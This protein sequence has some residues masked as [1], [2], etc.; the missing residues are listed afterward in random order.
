[1]PHT[2]ELQ[3]W[4][5]L[6]N[7]EGEL[8]AE[9]IEHTLD[10]LRVLASK[11]LG[12]FPRVRRWAETDDVLQDSIIRLHRALAEVRPESPRQFYGLAATQI[13]REL[14]DLA[15]KHDGPEPFEWSTLL[16]TSGIFLCG[17]MATLLVSL[18]LNFEPERPVEAEK[19]PTVIVENDALVFDGSYR[20]ITPVERFAPCTLEAWIMI[21]DYDNEQPRFIIGSDLAPRF[22]NSLGIIGAGLVAEYIPTDSQQ[23]I[24]FSD[25]TVPLNEWTHVAAVF[26]ETETRLYLNGK[27]V[28]SGPSTKQLG[29]TRFVIGCVGDTNPIDSFIGKVRSVRIAEGERYSTE[30]SP[31]ETFEND[32]ATLASYSNDVHEGRVLDISGNERHGHIRRP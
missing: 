13:R 20:I 21:E 23:G 9:I 15:R 6:A 26:G 11:M 1:M 25:A 8:R 2:T 32:T 28:V 19:P 10:R 24:I 17:A 16:K 12:R 29:G 4:L 31:E 18:L 27:H 3:N 14:I 7:A 5:N 22:G 30:F